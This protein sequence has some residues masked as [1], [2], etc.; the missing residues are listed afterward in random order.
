MT[1]QA[2]EFLQLDNDL[3]PTTPPAEAPVENVPPPAVS[4]STVQP[5]AD[6]TVQP[7]ASAASPATVAPPAPAAPAPGHVPL[8]AVLDEREKR[9]KAER[10]LAALQ[11]QI[12][13]PK[14]PDA[15]SDPKGWQA[16]QDARMSKFELDTRMQMSG[17]F[18]AQHYGQ[19]KVQAAMEWG[20]TQNSDDPFFGSK[21]TAQADPYGW[22]VEQHRQAQTLGLLGG[23]TAEEW[24]I[25]YAASQ[26]FVKPDGATNTQPAPAAPAPAGVQPVR[27]QVAPPRSI[28]SVTPA[29]ATN[30]AVTLRDDE[31]LPFS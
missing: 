18:A 1:E 7:P 10:E 15:T 12:Q 5:P 24:A 8:S 3:M 4:H 28:A 22:L 26:G 20:A 19:D 13:P 21:F 17:R 2:L 14:T 27:Q 11:A 16:A 29:G 25:E 23:K 6:Q 30:T 9:Q 31:L